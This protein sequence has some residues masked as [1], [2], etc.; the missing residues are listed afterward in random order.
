MS[1][2]KNLALIHRDKASRIHL[3]LSGMLKIPYKKRVFCLTRN[4]KVNA[5]VGSRRQPESNA[6]W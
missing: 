5:N 3:K 6:M 4:Q 1:R 2:R